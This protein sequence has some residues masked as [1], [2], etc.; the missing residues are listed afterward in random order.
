MRLL[1]ADDESDLNK[2]LAERLRREGYVVDACRDGRTA[3]DYME[4]VAYDCAVLDIMMPEMDGLS[5]VRKIRRE[6]S[7]IPVL[8]LT[9]LD[10]VQDRVAGLDA[11]AED[12]LV[13]PF[14]M[15]ELLARIRTLLRRSAGGGMSCYQVVDLTL[16]PGSRRVERSGREIALSARE[17]SLL[18]YMMRNQG[19]ALSRE[20]IEEHILDFEYEGGSN[21]VDVY[22][23]YLRRKIDEG[24]EKKLIHTI[25]GV[26]YML[27]GDI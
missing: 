8:F 1:L 2:I 3:C 25:R 10:S 20:Q 27:R 21:L 7:R 5:L 26:G 12:Y 23:R 24:Y 4:T 19:I 6:G 17:F 9:A 14:A 13:K 16:E 22:I 15:E 18:E 11:G